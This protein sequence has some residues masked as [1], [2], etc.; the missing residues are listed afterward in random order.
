MLTYGAD[1]FLLEMQCYM[2]LIQN[3]FSD[4]A[5][6]GGRLRLLQPKKGFRAGIDSVLLAASIT[7]CSGDSVLDVGTGAGAVLFCLMNRVPSLRATG[8]ELQEEYY[9][10]ALKNSEKNNLKAKILLGDFQSL[11]ND[12]KD[13]NFD[14]IFFNPPY[15]SE[16]TYK[17]SGN[18]AL[19]LANIEKPGM[20]EKMLRFSLKRCKP[21]GY[22]TL[23]NR[24]ARLGA[25]LSVLEKGAGDIKILPILSSGRNA[26]FR[27]IVRAK[28]SA[29]GET[30]LLEGLNLFQTNLEEKESKKY[31]LRVI[32]VL[33]QGGPL[34][35]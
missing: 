9:S 34:N 21:Y 6:L 26:V 13:C 20:L 16:R 14:H 12:F 35:F 15:Y 11:E 22:I 24:P 29:K 7:A 25:I 2:K 31:T 28:K 3:E 18:S 8:I 32:E 33:E 5:F 1:K 30:K 19:E 23:I 4:D 27:M 10:L 17:K